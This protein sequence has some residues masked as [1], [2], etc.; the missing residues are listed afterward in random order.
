M[1]MNPDSSKS[2]SMANMGQPGG[3][4]QS[5]ASG[6]MQDG[7]MR[8]QTPGQIQDCQA[9]VWPRSRPSAAQP[10]VD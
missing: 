8:M 1:Q 6:G 5:M 9:S 2:N 3:Q 4:P 10:V 7:K